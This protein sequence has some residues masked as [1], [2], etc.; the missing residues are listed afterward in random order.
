MKNNSVNTFLGWRINGYIPSMI[1]SAV[2]TVC[3]LISVIE[4]KN[5]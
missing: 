1:L 3:E 2:V 5:F 4:Q